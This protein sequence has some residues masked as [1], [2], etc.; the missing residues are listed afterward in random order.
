MHFQV[1]RLGAWLCQ[2]LGALLEKNPPQVG[3]Y[4]NFANAYTLLAKSP[5][6]PGVPPSGKPMTSLRIKWVEQS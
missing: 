6:Q 3:K 2:I 1:Q 4:K 5:H